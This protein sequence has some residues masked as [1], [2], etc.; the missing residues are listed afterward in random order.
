M[1]NPKENPEANWTTKEIILNKRLI[2]YYGP[3]HP[4]I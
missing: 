4:E 1:P 2:R 3:N